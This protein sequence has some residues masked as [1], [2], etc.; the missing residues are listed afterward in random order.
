[1]FFSIVSRCQF[2]NGNKNVKSKFEHLKLIHNDTKN[3][4]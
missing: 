1:M 2:L 3:N 4:L